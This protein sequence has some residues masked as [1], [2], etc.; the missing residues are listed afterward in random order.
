LREAASFGQPIAEYDVRCAAFRDYQ[1]LTKEILNEEAEKEAKI[2]AVDS[3]LELEAEEQLK[4]PAQRDIVFTLEAPEDAMVQIA[5]DFNNWVPESLH[6][7]QSMARPVWHKVIPLK[8]GTYE[9]KYLIDGRW[10]SDP[11]NDKV[12][13]DFL[14]GLNSVLNV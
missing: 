11:A 3:A 4:Q 1:N 7:T 2:S 12:V 9:Y 8:P 6:L 5:G 13:D 10:I 14:G